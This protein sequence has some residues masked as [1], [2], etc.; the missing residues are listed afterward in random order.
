MAI[1]PQINGE[2]LELVV[3]WFGVF[4]ATEVKRK[5]SGRSEL[6]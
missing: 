1:A 5:L 6:D 4:D 3:L 2:M